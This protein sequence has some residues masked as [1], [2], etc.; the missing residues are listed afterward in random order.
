MAYPNSDWP[1]SI[2]SAVTRVPGNIVYADDHNWQDNMAIAIENH[3]GAIGSP[4][5]HVDTWDRFKDATV[6]IGANPGR[7][8]ISESITADEN[9]TVPSNVIV[10]PL[11]GGTISV[12]ATFTVTINGPID[13]GPWQIFDGA[14]DIALGPGGNRVVYPEWWG[15]EPGGTAAS[16]YTALVKAIAAAITRGAIL[17]FQPGQYDYDTTLDLTFYTRLEGA[18]SVRDTG[19]TTTLNYTG[20][21]N[22]IQL[23]NGAGGV[24]TYIRFVA[25]RHMRIQALNATAI[26][27]IAG[28]WQGRYE[29][30]L[31][32]GDTVNT[33]KG[34]HLVGD[35]SQGVYYNVFRDIDIEG[36]VD[37]VDLDG[38]DSGTGT[39]RGN[40]NLFE[41]VRAASYTG[42][43]WTIKGAETNTFI[44]CLG[45]SASGEYGLR[46]LG[47]CFRMAFYSCYFEYNTIADIDTQQAGLS[48]IPAMHG[49]RYS[50]GAVKN[51]SQ[52]TRY[53]WR[54]DSYSKLA[55]TEFIRAFLNVP[56]RLTT[57]QDESDYNGSGSNGSF[58]GG[59]GYNTND[60]IQLDDNSEITVDAEVGNV[61]TEFTVSFIG[62]STGVEDGTTLNQKSVAPPGGTGFTLTPGTNNITTG[63]V[64]A[65]ERYKMNRSGVQ[66]W[67][68]GTNPTDTQIARF[69][70]D[71]PG[72]RV[73]PGV[74]NEVQEVFSSSNQL[75]VDCSDGWEVRHTLTENTTVQLPTNHVN[76]QMLTYVFRQD[77]GNSYTVSF[78]SAFELNNGDFY[79]PE[80]VG[81]NRYASITFKFHGGYS[82]WVEQ[83]RN[84]AQEWERG[85][86]SMTFRMLD[87]SVRASIEY[88]TS[89]TNLRLLRDEVHGDNVTIGRLQFRG[90]DDGANETNFGE[91]EGYC[92]QDANGSE[93]G[94][95][96]LKTSING[97]STA[98]LQIDDRGSR[99]QK[100]GH[101]DSVQTPTSSA[102]AVAVDCEDGLTVVHTLTEDTTIGAP[103]NASDGAVLSFTFIQ[104]STD[105]TVGFNAVFNLAS[106]F[107]MSTGSGTVD[108][109]QFQYV[110]SAWYEYGSRTQGM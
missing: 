33:A 8:V 45:E 27:Y 99:A 31:L 86:N 71:N 68:D 35:P 38:D 108:K 69:A 11:P 83:S 78:V 5:V 9:Y 62:A 6:T 73:S 77:V 51:G 50:G 93:R 90:Q 18:G 53:D 21:G 96:N 23:D 106:A 64:E 34:I 37:A 65:E 105:R 63:G 109:I 36:C 57:S 7:I 87:R 48:G 81:S 97:S 25:I 29:D 110:N 66:S 101:I 58:T 104:D 28:G 40:V 67:G 55:S 82:E 89:V 3:F 107:T 26:L 1:D 52:V 43:G 56:D 74:Y 102:G 70:S 49:C 79:M 75:D 46:I 42:A 10:C 16:N 91:I 15:C 4:V 94:R 72:L 44:L 103:S 20:A 24:G 98:I 100:G 95:L 2:D 88:S 80:G 60:V 39:A 13:A 30:L 32:K 92:V 19:I 41:R 17:Q 22:A 47:D 61:V 59:S 14:G 76:G 12:D 54:L 85:N 84:G